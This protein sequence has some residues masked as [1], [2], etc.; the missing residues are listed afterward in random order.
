MPEETETKS[1]M[2]SLADEAMT[3]ACKQ[4]ETGLRAKEPRMAEVLKNEELY[5]GK[6][7]KALKGRNNVP[8]DCLVM[9]GFID[10]ALSQRR[11]SP[12]I[13]FGRS[14][15][16]D[17]KSA[18]KMTA[19][20][21]RESA[22]DRANWKSKDQDLKKLA[23][24][25]GRG[26][27]KQFVESLPK[28]KTDLEAVDHFD[29]VTEPQGGRY[30][31][32]HLYKGQLNL[33]RSREDILGAS[34]AGFY[35]RPQVQKLVAAQ[36]AET[37]KRSEDLYRNKISRMAA[38]GINIDTDAYTGNALYNMFEWVMKFK[39]QWFYLVGS[40][41]TKVWVRFEPLEKV[42]AHAEDFVGRGPW[43]SY[44]TH[45]DP[46]NFWSKAPADDARP[47]A[48]IM[49]KVV[50]ST[51]DN[52]DKR[53]WDMKAVDAKMFPDLSKLNFR[54]DGVVPV[55]VPPGKNIQNGVYTFQTPDTTNITVNLVEYLK[56]F[57]GRETGVTAD[58]QGASDEKRVGVLVS[59]LQQ[60]S[61]RIDLDNDMYAQL[62]TDLGVMFDYGVEEH[63]REPY[64]IK[65]IGN[66]G[67]E[68]DETFDRD[69]AS[70]EFRIMVKGGSDE[71][72]ASAQKMQEKM[73]TLKDIE[74]NPLLLPKV[75]AKWILQEKLAG[76]WSPEEIRV[77]LDTANDADQEILAEAAE[78]IQDCLEGKRYIALNRRATTGFIEK[79]INFAED[80]FPLIPDN[81]VRRLSKKE[82]TKYK[83][84]VVK[85]EK[86]MKY[87]ADHLPIAKRN[88]LRKAMMQAAMA[89][90][91][92]GQPL[93]P[94]STVATPPREP[95]PNAPV[96]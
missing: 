92:P 7:E 76:K 33:F 47:I 65:L 10:T 3:V 25:S 1:P 63:L 66:Q 60:V 21:Q 73:A 41:D 61:A 87:A 43:A 2:E 49:K 56:N 86:L 11:E 81:E 91:A 15:E 70:R 53:N 84:G 62:Y 78:A 8:F 40:Y 26:I 17:L 23:L 90:P 34:A 28:F 67:I 24:L 83:E 72:R 9:G 30:L 52:L 95:A 4:L 96:L 77:A 6:T 48:H 88:M 58:A 79:I 5:L 57:L 16:Q 74:S 13:D 12:V 64:A 93:I 19:V 44:A 55:I 45:V 31:D 14:R 51:L 46:F 59:N 50:N 82:I 39:G 75:S 42:F 37:F 29:F 38:L 94:K 22:P 80:S 36:S 54:Q 69:D 71:L 85:Y 35:S 20:W 89:A 18:Q 27:A 68:W 32:K